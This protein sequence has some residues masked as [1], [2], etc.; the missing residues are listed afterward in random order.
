MSSRYQM[1]SIL[2][3]ISLGMQSCLLLPLLAD[4]ENASTLYAERRCVILIK[5]FS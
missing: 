4:K 5:L 2:A 3:C 1:H